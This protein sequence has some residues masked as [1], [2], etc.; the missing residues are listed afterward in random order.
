[1][2]VASPRSKYYASKTPHKLT[3]AFPLTVLFAYLAA[4][5]PAL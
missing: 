5:T 1:M 2:Y 4:S 3:A